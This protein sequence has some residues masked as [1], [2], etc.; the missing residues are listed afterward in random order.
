[1]PCLT[2]FPGGGTEL[3]AVKSY[4]QRRGLAL[5]ISCTS[6]EAAARRKHAVTSQGEIRE[7]ASYTC[8]LFTRTGPRRPRRAWC[9][10]PVF[11]ALA[12]PASRRAA[13]YETRRGH[14]YR[15]GRGCGS[16][17]ARSELR[18][19]HPGRHGHHGVLAAEHRRPVEARTGRLVGKHRR[20]LRRERHGARISGRR[21][22]A[23]SHGPAERSASLRDIDPVLPREHDDVPHRRDRRAGRGAARRAE[24]GVL[25]RPVGPDDELHP[26]RGRRGDGGP[27]QV[28]DFGL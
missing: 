8:V 6:C 22:R 11:D 24:P 1:M 25:E 14:R 12:G 9:G 10:C 20:R 7:T 15:H 3:G 26:A 27:G 23:L 17:Q 28:H 5:D 19:H 16:A 4:R 13:R 18:D 2:A 21:G